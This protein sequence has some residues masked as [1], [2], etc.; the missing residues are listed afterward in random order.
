MHSLNTRYCSLVKKTLLFI[1]NVKALFLAS[2]C[3]FFRCLQIGN[4]VRIKIPNF[5]SL[6]EEKNICKLLLGSPESR[7]LLSSFVDIFAE[8]INFATNSHAAQKAGFADWE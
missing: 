7:K 8:L 2:G 4:Y 1:C 3:R 6:P 5:V